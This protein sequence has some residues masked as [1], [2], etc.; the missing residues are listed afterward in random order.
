M[1]KLI[2][3]GRV[4]DAT[5][6]EN[7][8][9][10]CSKIES[11]IKASNCDCHELSA[12]INIIGITESLNEILPVLRKEEDRFFIMS[13]DFDGSNSNTFVLLRDTSDLEL[14]RKSID[15]W[16]DQMFEF[17]FHRS[18]SRKTLDNTLSNINL[19]VKRPQDVP[20]DIKLKVIL[21]MDS[22][23]RFIVTSDDTIRLADKFMHHRN[24]NKHLDLPQSSN[25][26]HP[27]Q[28]VISAILS[29]NSEFL[30]ISEI[31]DSLGMREHIDELIAHIEGC[32]DTFVVRYEGEVPDT[33]V[34]VSL[35]QSKYSDVLAIQRAAESWRRR[36]F[37][38]LSDSYTTSIRLSTVATAVPRPPV[39]PEFVK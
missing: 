32:P 38:Y 5:Y 35:H 26:I 9:H 29:G 3:S 31:K 6:T 18:T 28:K 36:I 22:L 37:N 14:I 15:S 23:K 25:S 19:S 1:S 13:E 10:L 12:L 8:S 30:E 11:A 16:R 27:N 24:E 21:L 2:L 7:R 20:R 39:L 4:L 33:K 34:F 17:L